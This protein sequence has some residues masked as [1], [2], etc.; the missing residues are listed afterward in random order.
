MEHGY[1]LADCMACHN[2]HAPRTIKFGAIGSG[3]T[4]LICHEDTRQEFIDHPTRHAVVNCMGCH[5]EHTGVK[6]CIDCH[7]NAHKDMV[8]D[9]DCMTCHK[10][11]HSP[12]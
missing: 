9:V 12:I 2:P 10:N 11:G 7:T 1:E 4:C 5:I 6:A 8:A 3:D